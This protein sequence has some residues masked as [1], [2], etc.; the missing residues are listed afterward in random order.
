M[1]TNFSK[2]AAGS[3]ERDATQLQDVA[4]LHDSHFFLTVAHM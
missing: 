4:A 2:T 3:A 1:E